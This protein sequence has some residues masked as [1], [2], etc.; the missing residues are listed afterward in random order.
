MHL[1]LASTC[2]YAV[3]VKNI[4]LVKDVIVPNN[5]LSWEQTSNCKVIKCGENWFIVRLLWRQIYNN[6]KQDNR[7]SSTIYNTAIDVENRAFEF[8]Y[9]LESKLNKE[10]IDKYKLNLTSLLAG[11]TTMTS[12]NTKC[13]LYYH[14]QNKS[15]SFLP[16]C[17]RLYNVW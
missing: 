4:H 12:S 14:Q 8:R 7:K 3:T 13:C 6:R 5:K 9:N 11:S 10:S 17:K 2:K 16:N 1:L 15:N